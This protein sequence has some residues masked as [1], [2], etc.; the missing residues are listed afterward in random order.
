MQM[1]PLTSHEL[2]RRRPTFFIVPMLI[3]LVVAQRAAARVRT[4][5]FLLLFA[6]GMLFGVGLVWCFQVLRGRHVGGESDTR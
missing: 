1:S 6:S 3:G 4:V 2:R 5:D